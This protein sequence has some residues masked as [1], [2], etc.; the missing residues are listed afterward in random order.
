MNAARSSSSTS[1]K[2]WPRWPSH[3][4]KSLRSWAYALTVA[5]NL[6][7]ATK[8]TKN[9]SIGGTGKES[10]PITVY[11]TDVSPANL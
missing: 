5:G 7:L 3:S 1:E 9:A 8:C 11:D 2:S 4:N 10:T 6:P